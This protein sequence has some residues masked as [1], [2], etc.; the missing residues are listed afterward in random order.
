MGGGCT[1]PFVTS[2]C[3]CS[4]S[5]VTSS[6]VPWEEACVRIYTTPFVIRLIPK[7]FI[8]SRRTNCNIW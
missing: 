5:S 3:M 7:T 6:T 2:P 4:I 1:S 8:D